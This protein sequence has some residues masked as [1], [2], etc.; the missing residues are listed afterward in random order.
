MQDKP[1]TAP[2][3]SPDVANDDA[4]QAMAEIDSLTEQLGNAEKTIA[5]LRDTMLRDRAD[6]ENQRRRMQTEL[7]NARRFANQR[8]LGDLLPVCDGLEHGL[9]V[10][11]DNASALREGMQL[12]L[13]S[14]LKV[15]EGN[16]LKQVD[17]L[18]QPFDPELHQAMS[19][20]PSAEYAPDTVVAVMQ[21]GYVLND[22][23]LRPAMVAVAKAPD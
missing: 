19:M 1:S 21:K 20:V 9:A 8:L 15:V 14:L 7:D 23:L 11:T 18:G 13:R 22:R 4:D 12:T 3:Q 17:P 16:G 6:L 2:G 10:D 5:D